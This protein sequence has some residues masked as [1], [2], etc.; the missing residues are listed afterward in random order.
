MKKQEHVAGERTRK[1]LKKQISNLPD[2]AFKAVV[3][4]MLT[5]RG[6]RTDERRS[7]TKT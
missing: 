1:T 7:S 4:E 3:I 5:E 2:N 6:R